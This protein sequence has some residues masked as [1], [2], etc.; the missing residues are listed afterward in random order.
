[1]NTGMVQFWDELQKKHDNVDKRAREQG[2]S[3]VESQDEIKK[4]IDD[5]IDGQSW[6]LL[7]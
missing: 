6:I 3:M 5:A 2:I 4:E 7:H 1:M